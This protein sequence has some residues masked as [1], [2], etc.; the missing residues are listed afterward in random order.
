MRT[1]KLRVSPRIILALA[2]AAAIFLNHAGLS[3]VASAQQASGT[4]ADIQVLPVQGNIYMV[5]G[6]GANISVSTGFDGT[7]LV[8]AG[9]ADMAEKVLATLEQLA[10]AVQLPFFPLAPCVGPRCPGGAGSG[11]YAQAG[12]SSQAVNGMVHSPGSLKPVRYIVNTALDPDHT[13]G[14][15]ALRAVGVTYTGGNVARGVGGQG[16]GAEVWAHEAVLNRMLAAKVPVDSHPQSTYYT[17][18]YKWNGFFN[19]EG[20]ELI[21]IP[22]AHTDGDTIVYFRYSDVIS[23]GDVFAIDRYPSIDV[24]R[25]GTIQGMIDGLN[26]ILDMAV[27]QNKSQ[28][29]TYI[30]PGH[31]RICDIGDVANYRNM[32]VRVHDRIEDLMKSGMTSQQVKAARP[33]LDFDGMYGSPDAFIEATYRSLSGRR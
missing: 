1:G 26:K 22:A 19:G 8:D 24:D 17:P 13:G 12:W 32:V 14:N 29:G 21:H 33:T 31:G 3:E 27:A 9:R 7:L 5:A 28:G 30:V 20:I 18:K 23:G 11:A 2:L 15:A 16:F 6:A 25:G 10:A 4:N